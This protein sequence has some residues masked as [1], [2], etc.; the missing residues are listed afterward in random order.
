ME[1][2]SFQVYQEDSFTGGACLRV[3]PADE[4]CAP[5]RYSRLLHADFPVHSP[6]LVCVVTKPLP[7]CPD[8]YLSVHLHTVT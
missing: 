1:L 5:Q 2:K 4:V 7:E 6:L 8:Q 3:H